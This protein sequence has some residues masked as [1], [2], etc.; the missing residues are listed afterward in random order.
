MTPTE[1]LIRELETLRNRVMD[2][3]RAAY[4]PGDRDEERKEK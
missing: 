2:R 4:A 1:T 3:R